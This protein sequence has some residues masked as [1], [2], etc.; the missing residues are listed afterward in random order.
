[1]TEFGPLILKDTGDEWIVKEDFI[2]TDGLTILVA[3][4]GTPTDGASIPRFFWRLI[5]SPLTGAYRKA[6]VIH[7]AGYKGT[8][9]WF[10]GCGVIDYDRE[11]V[12]NLF[13]ELMKALGVSPWRRWMMYR[14][15]RWFGQKPWDDNR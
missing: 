6:A 5:G 8:L 2:V 15:V 1:M 13:L 9:R 12:D 10:N 4:K 7:D 3:P 11:M 14:G